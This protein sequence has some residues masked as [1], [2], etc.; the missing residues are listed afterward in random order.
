MKPLILI[1]LLS[2]TWAH[3]AHAGYYSVEQFEAVCASQL[4]NEQIDKATYYCLGYIEGLVEGMLFGN[5]SAI[6]RM[7]KEAGASRAIIKK[8]LRDNHIIC[9]P[10]D[11]P[12]DLLRA[13]LKHTRAHKD[14]KDYIGWV[15]ARALMHEYPCE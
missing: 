8:A 4:D 3:N 6:H 11:A 5:A 15:A 10:Q 12:D 1:A 7:G 9:P 2:F 13:I 14:K